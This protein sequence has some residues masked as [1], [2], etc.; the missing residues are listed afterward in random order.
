[1]YTNPI[2]KW[3]TEAKISLLLLGHFG[4]GSECECALD[5]AHMVLEDGVWREGLGEVEA[6]LDLE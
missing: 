5:L 3:L 2:T 6:I 4:K 1:M